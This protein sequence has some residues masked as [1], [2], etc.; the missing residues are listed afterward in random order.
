MDTEAANT[1]A[2]ADLAAASPKILRRPDTIRQGSR[3]LSWKAPIAEEVFF[4]TD[5][6]LLSPTEAA[7]LVSSKNHIWCH[8]GTWMRRAGLAYPSPSP[9]LQS[10]LCETPTQAT[11]TK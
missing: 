10:N 2:D 1:R 4:D 8:C 6:G 7:A 5:R 9:E 11:M 3:K